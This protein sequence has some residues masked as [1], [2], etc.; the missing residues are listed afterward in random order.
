MSNFFKNFLTQSI[1]LQKVTLVVVPDGAGGASVT[2]IPERDKSGIKEL[3]KANTV[4]GTAEELDEGF[5][6]IYKKEPITEGLTVAPVKEDHEEEGAEPEKPTTKGKAKAPVK[7]AAAKQAPTKKAVKPAAKKK[8]VAPATGPNSEGDK[9]HQ[10]DLEE[11][12]IEET[13]PE[14]QNGE[15]FPTVANALD[16]IDTA[17]ATTEVVIEK[18][19]SIGATS[20]EEPE[21]QF[22]E[23]FF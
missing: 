10:A 2:I 23:T 22:A 14:E 16:K 8:T 6:G 17:E 3:V 4:A 21:G 12:L 13:E 7:K 15:D 5:F 1:G 20:S 19:S 9:H 18:G 11:N